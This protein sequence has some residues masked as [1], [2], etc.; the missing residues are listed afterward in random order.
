M[1]LV[2]LEQKMKLNSNQQKAVMCDL[3]PTIVIA[4]PG[5]GKTHVI[6]NRIN[7][8]LTELHCLA[9]QILV[10]TFSKLAA[11]EMKERYVRQFGEAPITFGTLHS[12][13]Y[14]I[15]RR[16][17]P[18]RYAL[19]Q[20]LAEDK[21]KIL[22]TQLLKEM[23][24]D[25]GDEFLDGFMKHLSLMKNQLI[26]PNEYQPDGISKPIFIE[27][28]KRYEA[29][30]ERHG[31]F[32]FDDMLV[33]CYYLLKNDVALCHA[34]GQHYR[35]VLVD[36]FQDINLVQFEIL[37]L[38]V[39]EHQHLFVVGDDDQSIYQF[40]G[41]KPSYLLD[42]KK[43][44]QN[45]QDIYLDVNYRCSGA[46]LKQSL[47]LINQN[48]V[49]YQKQLT[50]PNPQG[51]MPQIVTC[52]DAKEE[53]LHI[54]HEIT[55]RR[56]KGIPLKNMAVIY[57]TNIQAR[58]V[59]ETLLAANIP[60]CL[61]DGMISLYDQWITKDILS[62]LHLAC[63]MDQTDYA[64]R[65]INKPKRYMSKANIELARKGNKPFLFNLL[66]IDSLTEWQK[67]YV[68][69]LLFDLQVLREKSLL[70]AIH[71]IRHHIGYD[72]YLTEYA[73]YRKMPALSLFEVLED[74]EDSAQNYHSLEEWEEA[75]IEMSTQIKQ[76]AKKDAT[77]TL[78]L[79]TM[80]GSKGLEFDT[81]FIIDVVEGSIPYHKSTSVQEIEEERRLLYVGMTRAKHKLFLYVP[82]QK[83]GKKVESSIFIDELKV[84]ELKEH[85]KVGQKLRHKKLG[86]G[87]IIEVL[88][89]K[90]MM[91]QFN[92][93][94]KRKIDSHYCLKNDIIAWE[95]EEDEKQ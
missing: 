94:E 18:S 78:T 90:I 80:H 52:K 50:T 61:R 25:E 62:Y 33:E 53:A 71:Y 95:D 31:L 86:I 89:Q 2:R 93:G 1:N 9:H 46:I 14:R 3:R 21:R 66:E 4:G 11:E 28:L 43:H 34:V 59:V 64:Y 79:T 65:I 48:K 75:L 67:N 81:V 42:F 58:P 41:A 54:L 91:V 32:D 72:Q 7:Y 35:Y 88:E 17:N 47:L 6:V 70:E 82:T 60:F 63:S 8:M 39:Q 76:T 84:N 40:R 87:K 27:L 44:F 24:T 5:S 13:F 15:L 37:K 22:L 55:K 57:R 30:K 36:E 45:A 19:D 12:V 10:V 51:E 23:D 29:Y 92:N 68:Q 56:K 83:H 16:S 38:L 69:E 49:R 74:I 26:I 20:L 77:D 85:L 73:A